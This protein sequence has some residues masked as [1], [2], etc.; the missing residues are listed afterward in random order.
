MF[1]NLVGKLQETQQ[2]VATT[3]LCMDTVFI[4]ESSV[5]VF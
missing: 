5:A 1:G 2:K 3:K 4:D